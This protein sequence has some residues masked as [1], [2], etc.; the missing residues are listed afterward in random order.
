MSKKKSGWWEPFVWGGLI[1]IVLIILLG[2]FGKVNIA[3][4]EK[5]KKLK[6]NAKKP[7]E[8]IDDEYL[9]KQKKE[10]CIKSREEE[11]RKKEI[12]EIEKKRI[13]E[14]TRK[15]KEKDD[16][17]EKIIRYIDF[18]KKLKK[19]FNRIY[20]VTYSF[21]RFGVVGF[22][23]VFNYF[24]IYK[25][26]NAKTVEDFLNYNELALLGLVTFYFLFNGK[27]S[28]PKDTLYKIKLGIR[29]WIFKVTDIDER[30]SYY[31][32]LLLKEKSH[33]FELEMVPEDVIN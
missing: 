29:D 3:S 13:E 11:K 31:E 19:R 22:W 28:N 16:R 2:T 32:D 21:V 4:K 9:Q 20:A 12:L 33:L 14:Q 15:Q 23:L 27:I 7:L 6:K 17:I 24:I 30:I 1:A 5:K 18:L 26:G 8:I 10:A 25:L